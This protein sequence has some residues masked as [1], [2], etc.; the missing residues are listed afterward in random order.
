[1]VRFKKIV[2]ASV[3]LAT[4]ILSLSPSFKRFASPEYIMTAYAQPLEGLTR[5]N[6]A[7][8]DAL[9]TLGNYAI[10]GNKSDLDKALKEFEQGKSSYGDDFKKE[11]ARLIK[12]YPTGKQ[13]DKG[14]DTVKLLRKY[15]LES[16]SQTEGKLDSLVDAISAAYLEAKGNK[17]ALKRKIEAMG[18]QVT[19]E[20]KLEDFL[21][22]IKRNSISFEQTSSG[23]FEQIPSIAKALAL[24]E[25]AFFK[26]EDVFDELRQLLSKNK[27]RDFRYS[28]L[29][30][31]DLD[32]E[33]KLIALL[34]YYKDNPR[35]T[36]DPRTKNLQDLSDFNIE[37]FV[38]AVQ[39][40]YYELSTRQVDTPRL[41]RDYGKLFVDKIRARSTIASKMVNAET[42]EQK[43]RI[44]EGKI[45]SAESFLK[46]G[47]SVSGEQEDLVRIYDQTFKEEDQTDK[48]RRF[49]NLTPKDKIE[50]YKKQLAEL[51]ARA[52]TEKSK[53][54]LVILDQD[55]ARITSITLSAGDI[56]GQMAMA[57]SDVETLQKYLN[58]ERSYSYAITPGWIAR[59]DAI[60]AIVSSR[61]SPTAWA[62]TTTLEQIL[63]KDILS[64]QKEINA[65]KQQI[66]VL[67]ALQKSLNANG[68]ST[69][70]QSLTQQQTL[71]Q[72][73]PPGLPPEISVLLNTTIA[74]S[75]GALSLA[76]TDKASLAEFRL[77]QIDQ[78][79]KILLSINP[80]FRTRVASYFFSSWHYEEAGLT[81][82]QG[83]TQKG[84]TD[85][86]L[87]PTKALRS[88]VQNDSLYDFETQVGRALIGNTISYYSKGFYLQ[89]S[90]SQTQVPGTT[91][92][93]PQ[94]S[95]QAKKGQ[96]GTLVQLNQNNEIYTG[97]QNLSLET[98]FELLRFFSRGTEDSRIAG[99]ALNDPETAAKFAV[100]VQSLSSMPPAYAPLL[101]KRLREGLSRNGQ[102]PLLGYDAQSTKILF[103]AITGY[104]A[105]FVNLNDYRNLEDYWSKLP[106]KLN[107]IFPNAFDLARN[108]RMS[109]KDVRIVPPNEQ[110]D[111]ALLYVPS[112]NI[113]VQVPKIVYTAAFGNLGQGVNIRVPP[114]ITSAASF[115][116]DPAIVQKVFF[117]EGIVVTNVTQAQP[118]IYAPILALNTAA[119]AP[120]YIPPAGDWINYNSNLYG[121]F[122]YT[123]STT[124]SGSTSSTAISSSLRGIGTGEGKNLTHNMDVSYN[125]GITVYSGSGQ[126]N[127]ISFEKVSEQEVS[128]IKI[129]NASDNFDQF[130][131]DSLTAIG[132]NNAQQVDNKI[133]I[134]SGMQRLLTI[135]E[136]LLTDKELA[137]RSSLK[138]KKA[139]IKQLDEK[140]QGFTKQNESI[141]EAFETRVSGNAS[142]PFYGDAAYQYTDT[143]DPVMGQTNPSRLDLV[144]LN[145]MRGP[146]GVDD[147]LYFQRR[148]AG[149]QVVDSEAA[150]IIQKLLANRTDLSAF[151]NSLSNAE[152]EALGNTFLKGVAGTGLPQNRA[153]LPQFLTTNIYQ[154]RS[155]LNPISIRA[156]SS[157]VAQDL[158]IQNLSGQINKTDSAYL[159][160][161]LFYHRFPEGS[162]V[163]NR[164]ETLTA[165][166]ATSMYENT[167]KPKGAFVTATQGAGHVVMGSTEVELDSTF[168][169]LG[170][171][172]FDETQLQGIMGAAQFGKLFV[173]QGLEQTRGT[174][175]VTGAGIAD[176]NERYYLVGKFYMTNID[177]KPININSRIEK[178]KGYYGQVEYLKAG[179]TRAN[180][181]AGYQN[182]Q[183]QL[184]GLYDT[185]GADNY[186]GVG[187]IKTD[188][189]TGGR[190]YYGDLDLIKYAAISALAQNGQLASLA[191]GGR[192]FMRKTLGIDLELK[193][194]VA[195]Q[196]SLWSGG[197]VE[198]SYDLED[199]YL[200]IKNAGAKGVYAR[201]ETSKGEKDFL[202]AGTKIIIGPGKTGGTKAELEA[203]YPGAGEFKLYSGMLDLVAGGGTISGIGYGGHGGLRLNFTG[204]NIF[205]VGSYAQ[206]E[207]D[208]A[209]N[210]PSRQSTQAMVGIT[211]LISARPSSDQERGYYLAFIAAASAIQQ[212]IIGAQV[213][214][215]KSG[216]QADLQAGLSLNTDNFF[217]SKQKEYFTAYSL[218]GRAIAKYWSND[219][220]SSLT[221]GLN[222]N[223]QSVP[224][225]YSL[226]A[227]KSYAASVQLLYG[228]L[229]LNIPGST[230]SSKLFSVLAS[231]TLNFK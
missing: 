45:R 18:F 34:Y 7:A 154:I 229:D 188:T 141:W 163:L 41:Y 76:G 174:R 170:K 140:L 187:A 212:D 131:R 42:I 128:P 78:M 159:Y 14:I 61:S 196:P 125:A 70:K 3:A 135:P 73:L 101:L 130:E 46:N 178:D 56:Y 83:V 198:L 39:D 49:V 37:K 27:D 197:F 115:A 183:P 184:G 133:K 16:I 86:P 121:N 180:V 19:N 10:T 107:K 118:L 65:L 4:S 20:R 228:G 171:G 36:V 176:P 120:E 181:F 26:A 203:Y 134:I 144:R 147:T 155:I 84:L 216:L 72:N 9:Q 99:I 53:D 116:P 74:Q 192:W 106:G 67:D 79:D 195:Y 209:L 51:R 31:M 227:V 68:P 105:P 122:I 40:C 90:A 161:A 166:Q 100:V 221:G 204:G 98:K 6:Q 145:L 185:V 225:S 95:A 169:S 113:I 168:I 222:L 5:I 223:L 96:S 173:Y 137:I 60:L 54:E 158:E 30:K 97:F 1:M 71:L 32:S 108:E 160:D 22:T 136:Y 215:S 112:V 148:Y 200:K 58:G 124:G 57:I 226:G 119:L 85:A 156:G 109:Q 62:Y 75:Q 167:I 50:F 11:F 117:Q 47:L 157:Q 213:G 208:F 207:Q 66:F 94:T 191:S 199:N 186:W 69:I 172:S 89:Q 164:V 92:N 104:S 80:D 151:F 44:L 15:F 139:R 88:V 23:T 190:A 193:G 162:W 110:R 218:S 93:P 230:Y 24:F 142:R 217:D 143:G 211:K 38:R 81:R 13:E 220:S 25:R 59:M 63:G 152:Y 2:S 55:I 17:G 114:D 138:A 129:K 214:Q 150:G 87:L 43:L 33:I 153:D 210:L 175:T 48:E 177:G 231:F 194:G 29:S 123:S 132:T 103:D 82:K 165:A 21:E 206:H 179:E 149:Q 52:A 202:I 111:Y 126:F 146:Q 182:N 12:E 8:K 127:G 77:G 224:G 205:A 28:L 201:I 219:T 35:E 102:D 64:V 189:L 91:Q